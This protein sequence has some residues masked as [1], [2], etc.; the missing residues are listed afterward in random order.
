MCIKHFFKFFLILISISF[1]SCAT[2]QT[3][4]KKDA[5]NIKAEIKKDGK[6]AVS[7]VKLTIRNSVGVEKVA[8]TKDALNK[9]VDENKAAFVKAVED[10]LKKNSETKA[11][12]TKD[13][14]IEDPNAP[15][16]TGVTFK[17]SAGS[18]SAIAFTNNTAK[19]TQQTDEAK[20][21]ISVTLKADGQ[22]SDSKK[23]ITVIVPQK[24][25]SQLPAVTPESLAQLVNSKKAEL[26][27]AITTA[28]GK[29]SGETANGVKN[30]FTIV[31]PTEGFDG[32]T[33]EWSTDKAT[34][35]SFA[36]NVATVTRPESSGDNVVCKIL[37][38][39]TKD[40][41][42]MNAP[43]EVTSITVLKKD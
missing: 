36:G 12:V 16:F 26:T 21:D 25:S 28:I 8:F 17:W 38:K 37:V 13:F 3:E 11:A 29:N 20:V 4:W 5:S 9:L 1:F 35:L 40:S 22:E 10:A 2:V 33:F 32:V 42:V 34:N 6:D 31:P 14:T 24:A 27:T 18:G 41:V 15:Q 7:H 19:V 30:N 23:V 39:L 43:V